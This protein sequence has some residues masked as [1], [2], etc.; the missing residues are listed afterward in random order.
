MGEPSSGAPPLVGTAPEDRLDSWKE[1]AAYLKRDITTVQRWEKREGMPVRRHLHDKLG[2]VY[3]FRSELDAWT[4]SRDRLLTS[5]GVETE[6]ASS[7][8]TSPSTPRRVGRST[9]GW[10]LTAGGLLAALAAT[11][12]LLQRADY[13]WHNPLDDARFQNVTDFAGTEQAAA[14]SRDGRFVAFLSDRDGRMDVWVTQV[15]TGQ[16][17]NLTRGRVRELV[18]PSV[19]TLGFSPDG[20]LVT[21]WAR[22]AEGS[23]ARDISVLAVSPLG[24]QPRPYLEGAAEFDWSHDGSRLVYHTPGP[25]DPMF[26]RNA[27]QE[28]AGG[29]IFA[30]APGL[31]A[32]F[33]VWSPDG[34]FIYFVQ[35]SLPDA[36]DIWRIKPAGGAA[37]RIT[38]HNSRVSHPVLLD[39]RTLMY[40]AGDSDGSGPWLHGLDVERRVPHRVGTGV[41]RYT[42]LAASADG[43]RLVATLANPRGTLWRLRLGDTPVDASAATPISLTTARGFSPRLGPGCLLYVSSKGASDGI[44]KLADGV[45]TELWSAP[46]ARIIGGPEIAP[47]GQRVAFSVELRG[48]TL[49]YAMNADGTNARVVSETLELRGTPAWAPDGNSITSAANVDGMPRLFR[50]PL[51][52]AAAPLVGEYSRDPV[53]SPGGDFLVYSGADVGTTFP[54]KAVDAGGSAYP[55]PTLSLT[56]GARRLRF[57]DG[58]HALVVMRGEIQHKDL[59]LIDLNTGAERQL[60]RLAPDFNVRGFRRISGRPRG[61]PRARSGSVGRHTH[62]S[63]A[64]RLKLTRPSA[65]P[66]RGARVGSSGTDVRPRR[67]QG[68]NRPGIAVADP[69]A[70]SRRLP[71][72]HQPEIELSFA[73]G[74]QG[75]LSIPM[76]AHWRSP[77]R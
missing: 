33:P 62:R 24:G 23:D 18:N 47:D 15:G 74:E 37:E 56:R 45:A 54:V 64:A 55:F 29:P 66:E 72:I 38:H 77:G 51:D 58:R 60:T 11:W 49:L 36:M 35:G 30:A 4:R 46:G 42:S 10:S 34:A 16:F 50:I 31:H 40:L 67:D 17:Y 68:G 43:R 25:G 39:R 53:W 21:F 57:L 71:R 41:D 12:W 2:S 7:S 13:F 19:R 32:H 48:R 27:G 6:P 5:E 61:R 44:W 73:F 75:P 20:A 9:F 1:I 59:W 3:A 63:S 8:S 52:G 14:V 22:G 28:T 26:V 69:P 65:G 76:P 70:S